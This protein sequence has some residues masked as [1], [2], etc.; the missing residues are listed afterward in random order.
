MFLLI[1]LFK[2]PSPAPHPAHSAKVQEAG[3][4]LV[5]KILAIR[6]LRSGQ[7]YSAVGHEFSVS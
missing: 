1:L 4:Y 7:S 6:K 3:T 5:D 2:M